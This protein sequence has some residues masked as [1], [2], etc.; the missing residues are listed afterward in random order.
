M[1]WGI[2]V[3]ND[4]T[5]VMYVWFDALTNYVNVIGYGKDE[6]E[7]KRWWPGIQVCGPDNLRFQAPIWQGML[8]SAKLPQTKALLVHGM[9]LDEK[10]NKMS[11]SVGN[12]ISPFQQQE[13]YGAEVVRYYLLAGL[14]TYGDASYLES[15]LVN[16]YNSNL[17]NNFGNLLLRVIHLAEKKGAEINDVS[18]VSTDFKSQVDE[19]EAEITHAYEAYEIH[20]AAGLVNSLADLGNKYIDT[21]KPWGK[22]D[23]EA[24]VILN[25]LSYLLS[26]V[27][28]YYEPIIPKSSKKA[29]EALE[30]REK[31]VLFSKIEVE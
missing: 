14:T 20:D 19:I 5:Q 8:A 27:I 23:E 17:A 24:K 29:R 25:N 21:E 13:K 10:G 2:E 28:K 1:P 9:I 16:L 15:D 12:V 6:D 30:N 26:L 22:G 18:K 3:P 4:P 11:K 31:V 7:L